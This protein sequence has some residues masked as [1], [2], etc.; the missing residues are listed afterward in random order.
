MAKSSSLL[1][2]IENLGETYKK[3]YLSK[4]DNNRLEADWWY[5]TDFFFDHSFMR[6]RVDT[7]SLEYC[8]F[9]KIVLRDL[10]QINEI[11]ASTSI[12]KKYSN[13]FQE[14]S[15]LKELKKG[16]QNIIGKD[17]I[18]EFNQKFKKNIVIKTL[19]TPINRKE[20]R[21]GRGICLENDK[22][23][24]MVMSYFKH[25]S[26]NNIDNIYSDIL[27]KIKQG[28]IKMAYEELDRID[29][30][31]DKLSTFIIRDIG[32]LNQGLIK[33][34]DYE[35]ALPVDTWVQQMH[36]RLNDQNM[37]QGSLTNKTVGMIRKWIIDLSTENK[38]DA[39]KFAAGLWVL[40][41]HSF[42]ILLNNFMEKIVL[43]DFE[44]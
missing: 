10:F 32:L 41:Y 18:E 5:A 21:D 25:L 19:T 11:P 29:N 34:K 24:L 35:Y 1:K 26:S 36:N 23:L 2:N 39:L 30:I 31:G 8:K 27:T 6:G 43:T 20:L 14:Y 42:D 28:K 38:I 17:R 22:D 15:K 40:G 4:W 3:V 7:V 44:L 16:N 13:Y 37:I 12:L 33:D 9:T